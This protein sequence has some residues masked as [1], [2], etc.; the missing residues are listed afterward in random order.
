MSARIMQINYHGIL[1]PVT[2]PFT[3]DEEFDRRGLVE[4]LEKWSPTGITG[5]VIL[6]STGERVNL[7]EREYV[8]VIETARLA[9]PK[10]FAFV[11]GAGEQSTRGTIREIE[12]A[13][14]AGAEATLV[15]TP[16]YYRAAISQDAL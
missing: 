13:A 14:Q 11:V 2:T 4:N 7:D 10:E 1:L 8:D 16:H 12:V 15:I 3:A 9:V 6:G 5:Y